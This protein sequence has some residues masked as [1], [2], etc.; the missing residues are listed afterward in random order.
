MLGSSFWWNSFTPCS[1]GQAANTKIWIQCNV[2]IHQYREQISPCMRLSGDVNV[3]QV[4][5]QFFIH[6]SPYLRSWEFLWL[7][8]LVFGGSRC[9]PL[10]LLLLLLLWLPHIQNTTSPT[11]SLP[12]CQKEQEHHLY[13]AT[14][15]GTGC[16]E[17][18]ACKVATLNRLSSI[19]GF[20]KYGAPAIEK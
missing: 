16:W 18:I 13:Y 3:F 4:D 17:D 12:R 8:L 19:A 14:D 2:G 7:W 5:F 10:F 15:L 1:H 20:G 11:H 9:L 6:Q